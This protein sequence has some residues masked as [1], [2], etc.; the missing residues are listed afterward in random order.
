[1]QLNKLL[2]RSLWF[3]NNITENQIPQK[4]SV[5]HSKMNQNIR[6][7]NQSLVPF[8]Q[9]KTDLIKA[10]IDLNFQ[11]LNLEQIKFLNKLK[12]IELLRKR[13]VEQ[14]EQVLIQNNLGRDGTPKPQVEEC[15]FDFKRFGV[16]VPLV[17]VSPRIQKSTV[18]RPAG[19]IPYDHTSVIA[20]ILKILDIPKESWCLGA[21][22]ANAPTF[23]NVFEGNSI[24]QDIPKVEVNKSPKT[25][26]DIGVKTPPNDIHL[27]IAHSLVNG[28][29]EKEGLNKEETDKLNLPK[30][31][32]SKTVIELSKTLKTA[33]LKIK[34]RI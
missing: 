2:S 3:V 29:I 9:E 10:T 1:M 33:V 12:I 17:L 13:G 26:T 16:R 27:R 20:T 14:I 22:T 11:S 18:F 24:R 21:R 4:Y 30:L 28:M 31:I 23:E 15:Q 32:E 19:D 34:E 8:E 5:L 6:R 25:I 7:N